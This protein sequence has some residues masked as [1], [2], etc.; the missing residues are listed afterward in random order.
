MLD[1][2]TW[3]NRKFATSRFSFSFLGMWSFIQ[4]WYVFKKWLLGQKVITCLESSSPVWSW[5]S[6]VDGGWWA[7]RGLF[8]CQTGLLPLSGPPLKSQ[9]FEPLMATLKQKCFLFQL[10]PQKSQ[11]I[12]SSAL[13]ANIFRIRYLFKR[14]RW[15]SCRLFVWSKSTFAL[16]WPAKL[17]SGARVQINMENGL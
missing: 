15:T 16:F 7:R 17:S 1:L 13:K 8:I 12:N 2:V 6:S 3:A 5:A 4:L 11:T 9:G 10:Q 14:H